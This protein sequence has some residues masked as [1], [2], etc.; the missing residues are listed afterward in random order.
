MRDFAAQR[1]DVQ[2]AVPIRI[3][4]QILFAAREQRCRTHDVAPGIVVQRHGDLYQAL[5]KLVVMLRRFPP[6]VFEHLVRVEE[7]AL[8]EEPNAAPEAGFS[9]M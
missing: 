1:G 9:G 5:N 6:F 7:R 3:T 2:F 8:V 4:G